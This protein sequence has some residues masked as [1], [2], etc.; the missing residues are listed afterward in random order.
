[1][2]N[3]TG[4]Q[5][6]STVKYLPFGACLQ[7]PALPTDKLFTGQRLD[8]TTS[9]YYFNARYYEPGIGKFLSPDSVAPDQLNPQSLNKYAY[10]FNN[11]LKYNDPTGNWPNWGNIGKAIKKAVSATVNFVKEHSDVI[12]TVLDVAGMIPVVGE[13]FDAVNGI[14]YAAQGDKVNAAMS[15]ASCIPIAGAV[16]GGAKLAYK[17]IDKVVSV[18]KGALKAEDVGASLL[19][20]A[21]NTDVYLGIKKSIADYAGIA[22]DVPR[23]QAQHGVRFDYLQ[24][25]TKN[26]VTRNQ[27]RAIEQVLIE[28]NTQFSN[29]I[30]SISPSNPIYN[31]AIKWGTDWLKSNGYGSF[32]K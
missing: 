21:K 14:I 17:T 31:D 19:K 27:A 29:V 32:L 4:N 7:S 22:Y 10:C 16:L 8:A 12:H 3:N 28:N 11:P 30:N 9:I 5:I 18:V 1:M 26:K 23:R 24:K 25:I 2:T 20:G 13:A 6:G 15:F